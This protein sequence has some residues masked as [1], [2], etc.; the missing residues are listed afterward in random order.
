MLAK[1][2]R[3]I[4]WLFCH[5]NEAIESEPEPTLKTRWVVD[6]PARPAMRLG[7]FRTE[8]EALDARREYIIRTI[9]EVD[10]I[11]LPF[12]PLTSNYHH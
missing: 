8:D 9:R 11:E 6:L 3:F 10:P 1:L 5:Q 12:E 2:E 7:N 4:D